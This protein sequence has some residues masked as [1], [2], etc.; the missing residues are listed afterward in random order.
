MKWGVGEP[1]VVAKTIHGKETRQKRADTSSKL[2]ELYE[3]EVMARVAG[4]IAGPRVRGRRDGFTIWNIDL[5][6]FC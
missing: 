3:L 4:V 1:W 6:L 5:Y 2:R